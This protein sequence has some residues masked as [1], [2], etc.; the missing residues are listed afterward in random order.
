[1]LVLITKVRVEVP[2]ITSRRRRMHGEIYGDGE[3][4]DN[5]SCEFADG[6]N[7]RL[8]IR[9]EALLNRDDG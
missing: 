5:A 9:P 6:G 8:A 7:R 2:S 4:A 3:S 1:M